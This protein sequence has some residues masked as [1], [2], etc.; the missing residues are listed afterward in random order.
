[1]IYLNFQKVRGRPPRYDY[2]G[3]HGVG[4]CGRKGA[5]WEAGFMVAADSDIITAQRKTAHG[6]V[7]ALAA[8]LDK[9]SIALFGSDEIVN[10]GVMP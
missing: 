8:E 7:R 9:R 1:M 3:P 5:Q 6:A 10:A 2:Q 4:Y